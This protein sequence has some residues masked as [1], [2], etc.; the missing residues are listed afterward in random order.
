V[1]QVRKGL[2]ASIQREEIHNLIILRTA[3]SAGP[4]AKFH[5]AV[6]RLNLTEMK[7]PP[8]KRPKKGGCSAGRPWE[9]PPESCRSWWCI[10]IVKRRRGIHTDHLGAKRCRSSP[11]RCK[12]GAFLFSLFQF[13]ISISEFQFRLMIKTVL[14]SIRSS[15][16]ICRRRSSRFSAYSSRALQM[17]FAGSR[18]CSRMTFSSCWRSSLSLP[19]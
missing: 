6:G 3:C 1:G 16:P 9:W 5:V 7:K 15:S 18:L 11:P 13:G 4:R 12:C 2:S 17:S 14:S 8:K 19:S 10:P